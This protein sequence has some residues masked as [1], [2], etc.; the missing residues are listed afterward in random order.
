[1]SDENDSMLT[2]VV[3][4]YS[5][6]EHLDKFLDSLEQATE[7]KY[8]VLLADN[9]STDGA[10][11][12]AAERA[13]V[14]LMRT[15]GNIGYGAAV[16][17]ALAGRTEGWALVANPDLVWGTECL[18]MMLDATERW[19][20]AGALGPAILTPDGSLYPS[21]RALP[22]LGTGIGHAMFGWFWPSNPWTAKY[23]RERGAPEEG[24]T[25][26]LSG[27]CM[28]IRLSAFAEVGGFDAEYFMYFEDV[29]LC[30]RLGKAGWLSVHVPSAIVEHVQGHAAHREP[31][32][33]LKAHH[34]SAYRYLSRRY[35]GWKW[36]PVRLLLRVGLATRLLL[37]RLAGRVGEGA[38]PQRSAD[39]LDP[40]PTNT[41]P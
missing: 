22:S 28:L 35:S 25:G 7:V 1:M 18:D 41:K 33:M 10:P 15:G 30:D 12:R 2:V 4:T 6:G 26:W 39:V 16:N 31:A 17:L 9:G 37:S 3:V 32:A 27:S 8:S 5:P 40:S 14:T 20:K 38:Q 29:D 36:A 11:E 13:N 34:R 19:P 21:A 24:P 23:R